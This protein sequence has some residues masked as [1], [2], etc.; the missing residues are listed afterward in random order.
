MK[1]TMIAV[2]MGDPAGIGPEIALASIADPEIWERG[3]PLLVGDMSV[4][5]AVRE[6]LGMKME[7]RRVEDPSDAEGSPE[8]L[9]VLDLKMVPDLSALPVGKVSA[10]GGKAS[11]AYIRKCVD[12][13]MSGQAAGIA[14]TPINK[15]SLKAA[16]VHYIGHTEMLAEMSGAPKS[17]TMFIVD[18][19]RILFHSRHLSLR[20]AIETLETDDVVHSIETAA[21]CLDSIGLDSGT[22]A[23][24][25]L[26]PHSSDGGL[27]GD[28]E[29]R[30]LTPAVEEAKRRGINVVGPVPA[31]SVFYFGLQGKYDVVVSLYHDQGHIASKTY[32][33]Y[34]TVSVTFGLPFIRTSVD[35]GTAFDIAWKGIA[36]P[37][38][39]KEAMLACFD[40]APRYR[41]F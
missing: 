4:L 32:D 1:R 28:E 24:A 29:A 7:L 8:S 12:L 30:V 26:N 27:F 5:E 35:H 3:T 40:I 25:G 2:T 14:T 10:L 36:N 17:Y 33:F 9:P 11:V 15:E 13:C 38:S 23:L 16:K 21:K 37:V 22:I 18:K 20:R 31:D 34:R 6:T 41:P 39:M 19:L